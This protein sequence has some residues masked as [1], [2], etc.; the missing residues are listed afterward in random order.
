MLAKWEAAR[1]LL[2]CGKVGQSGYIDEDKFTEYYVESAKQ[3]DID[4]V[5]AAAAAKF[6]Y[7][8]TIALLTE[9]L[10]ELQ[11]QVTTE[12]ATKMTTELVHSGTATQ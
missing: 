11:P 5:T 12:Y 9:S 3:A 7:S 10:P 1:M 6:P 8:I 4:R 2:Q